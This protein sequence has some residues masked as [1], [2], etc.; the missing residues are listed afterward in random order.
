M[1]GIAK[2]TC[3]FTNLERDVNCYMTKY[4]AITKEF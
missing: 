1:R 3:G 2:T 4:F